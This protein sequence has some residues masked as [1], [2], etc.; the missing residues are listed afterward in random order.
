MTVTHYF[1]IAELHNDLALQQKASA[2][3]IHVL[4]SEYCYNV[5]HDAPLTADEESRL[6]H[7]LCETFEPEKFARSQSFL[8]SGDQQSVVEVGPRQQFTSAWSTNAVSICAS[9]GIDKVSRI[10]RSRRF[11]ISGK[12]ETNTFA[13]LVHDRMTEKVYPDGIKSFDAVVKPE[14]WFTIPVMKEGRAAL[15]KLSKDHGLGYDSQDLDYYLK[16]FQEIGRDPTVVECYDLAQGNSEH[17]RHWFFGGHIVI[18][19]EKMPSTLFQLVKRPFKVNPSNSTIAFRD[20]SSALRGF[21]HQTLLPSHNGK[22]REVTG[23]VNLEP[24]EV[25]RDITLTVETHNFPCGIAPFPGAET[26]AGGRQRDGQST[27]RGSLV[28]A[29]IAAYCVGNL[30]LP[31]YDLPWED[32]AFQYPPTMASPKQ[33]LIDASNGAS[34]YGNKFG[35]PMI[36]GY[37][38]SFGQKLANGERCEWIK[39]I[40]LSGGIGQMD[41]QHMNKFDPEAGNLIIKLGGPAYRIGVGGGSAS[42]MVAGDNAAELDFNAVQRGDAE[43]MQKVNRVIRACIELGDQNPLLSIHDQGCGGSGNVLKEICEGAGAE[44]DLRKM[45]CG[46][47]S[48]T[49]LELW[50]AEY[51][52][53]DAMLIKPEHEA[54]FDSICTREKVPYS[55]VGKITGTGRVVVK[56]SQDGSVPVDLPLDKVLG[57]MPQKTFTFTRSQATYS[58]LPIPSDLTVEKALT[59]GVLRLVAVGS[60]RYLTNK[61]DRSVTGQIA[62]QQCVGPLQTPLANCAVIAQS[63]LGNTGGVTSIGEAPM[64]AL[65]GSKEDHQKMGRLAVAEA[66]TNIVWVKIP[67]LDSIKASGNWMWAAKLPGEGPKM[68]DTAEAIS[69]IMIELGIS[70]DGGKDSL[71]MAAR[72]PT[73][74]GAPETVKCPGEMVI[75]AYAPV[76]DV[77]I[78]VTPDLKTAGDGVLL[79]IDLGHGTP[80]LGGS[81]LAQVIG[82]VSCGGSPDVDVAALRA[83]FNTTQRLVDG[84]LIS[85]GHDR[86]DGGLIVTLLEMAF[87]GNKGISVSLPDAERES[88]FCQLFAEAPGF[89]YE[90]RAADLSAVQRLLQSDGVQYQEIG[91][92]RSDRKVQ[93]MIGAEEVLNSDVAVLRD[94]W[95]AT[96]FRLEREQTAISCVEQEEKGLKYRRDPPFNLTYHPAPTAN[97]LL[98][99]SEKPKVA[100]IR[101]EGSNGDREMLAS[102]YLAGFE[103][104]DVH[105][106]DL[107][108]GKLTLD[109]FRGV[110]FVGGFS[111]ADVMDSAKGWAGCVRFNQQLKEQFQKFKSRSDTFSLGVC[112]GC[113]LM[114]LLGW[115][116]GTDDGTALPTAKQP[117]FIHNRSGRFES[118]FSTIRVEA[119]AATQIWLQGM[120][121]SRLGVWVAH[122]EGRAHFP[123]LQVQEA[124]RRGGQV[125]MRYVD[126]DGDTTEVYPFNPNGS[127]E[128]IVGLCSA[129]GRHLAMM[130]HPER[131]TAAMWQW[132]W[133]PKEW[134]E[135]PG[136]LAASPWLQMFQNIRA[137][138]E[139]TDGMSRPGKFQK[140]NGYPN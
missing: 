6:V 37:S 17:S 131:L 11:A 105:M 95:E 60:K 116:P 48:M 77:R 73:K 66:L 33:I 100:I 132:P 135:G 119:S 120:E 124:V 89:V 85:A 78:K 62:Q 65:S 47:P 44:I 97:A 13:A 3:N 76:P 52:E 56:D 4:N 31:D 84:G 123:D 35:E 134:T 53:N 7:L 137:W 21:K 49:V 9:C 5:E 18:D 22:L 14:K 107:A 71:S 125:P 82:K 63:L 67:S 36:L 23:P 29:G 40:M 128:G 110:A 102:F 30:N 121:G 42:S 103:S 81:A 19:G 41:N 10:E 114:A 129:D 112:N 109:R 91:R 43:M 68:Y 50:I 139:S 59:S 115:V 46:D 130:P 26:G 117:R 15:E 79:F 93:V 54:L 27:G 24:G 1:R 86:S 12:S 69:K 90:V 16:V 104:W 2:L 126:D 72:V 94:I 28:V 138:C 92:T 122:G 136:Q 57:K 32:K 108:S 111:F 34:D 38:R 118:R 88:M 74:A 8:K 133:A 127:P 113:Q 101:Q 98:M 51:Q 58:A 83:A 99:V 55:V 39:P 61:V 140:T 80:S 20:N 87:A 106:S 45:L 75:T 96:S 25:D 70:I 64:K